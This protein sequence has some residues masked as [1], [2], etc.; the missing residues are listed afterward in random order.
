MVYSYADREFQEKV[1]YLKQWYSEGLIH[2]DFNNTSSKNNF[3][4]TLYFSDEVEGNKQFGF[5]TMDWIATTTGGSDKI[6][7]LLPPV[8]TIS[9][10]GITRFIHYIENTRSIKPDG[11]S[12]SAAAGE[13]ERNAALLLFDYMFSSEGKA[14]QNYSIPSV[15]VEGEAFIGSDGKSYPKFNQWFIDKA[16][17]LLNGDFATF[18]RDYMGSS[19]PLGYEKEIGVELQFTGE[20]G[21][22]AWDLYT[23]MNVLTMT[24][25]STVPYLTLMPPIISLTEK[26]ISDLKGVNI[27]STLTNKVFDYITGSDQSLTGIQDLINA[28]EEAGI[29]QYLTV[30]KRAYDRMMEDK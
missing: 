17:E 9:E 1:D 13:K 5:M 3:R 29:K 24:Y 6:E 27:S 10:A 11:W 14:V 2:R 4:Q 30:Y 25:G 26:D 22:K 18:L 12:I 16:A 28:Y 21:F 15:W 7:G 19:L 8:T 20:N 23:D